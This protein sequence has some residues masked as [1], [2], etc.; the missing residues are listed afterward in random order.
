[1]SRI[2]NAQNVRA[3][4]GRPQGIA[5]I[6]VT[7]LPIL[8]LQVL[9]PDLPQLMQHFR[10]EPSS[11][12]LVPMI[13][14]IPALCI[15]LFSSAA[16]VLADFWGRRGLLLVALFA[17]GALGMAPLLFHSLHGILGSR[18]VVGLAEA[19]AVTAGSSLLG[20]YFA[21][22]DR[23]RWLSYQQMVTPLFAAFSYLVGGQL[24][25]IH[26]STPFWLYSA[27]FGVF[28]VAVACL[29]PTAAKRTGNT[30]QATGRFPWRIAGLVCGV[31]FLVSLA[32][33]SQIV[34]HGRIF[35]A[36]GVRSP[37]TIGRLT[38]VA[39]LTSVGGAFLFRSNIHRRVGQL[40]A[41]ML[42]LYAVCYLGL[43]VSS[44]VAVGLPLDALGM[45]ASG[46][47][48][49]SCV[50]W[51]LR[52]FPEQHRG[53]GMGLYTASFY[54]GQFASAPLVTLLQRSTGGFMRAL[55]V[56]GGACVCGVALTLLADRLATRQSS[57]PTADYQVRPVGTL[58]PEP[59]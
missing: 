3:P 21:D 44:G 4:A 24:A 47:M 36:L 19:C 48:V 43:S 16:G 42:A 59:R 5:L 38:M 41:S 54:M 7:A 52:H 45:V 53:R 14:T 30:T 2:G 32:F 23:K 13:L 9:V 40:L 31:T 15:A 26:W 55:A 33:W 20:D 18:I 17:Y 56:L 35:A 57:S 27:A 12:L 8:A 49:P 28:V 58:P 29:P 25:S 39:G 34:Q 46:L 1:M 51:A 6:M 11:D 22:H 37:A 50:P 10:A